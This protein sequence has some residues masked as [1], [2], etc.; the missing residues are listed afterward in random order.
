MLYDLST[1]SFLNGTVFQVAKNVSHIDTVQKW[2]LN[3]AVRSNK[4]ERAKNKRKIFST[5]ILVN[6][7]QK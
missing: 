2:T 7:C 4:S 5:E 1:G 6:A 3:S